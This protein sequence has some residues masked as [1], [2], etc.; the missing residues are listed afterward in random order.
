MDNIKLY[1]TPIG[2]TQQFRHCGNPL[3]IDTYKGCSFGCKYCFA[4]NRGG[5]INFDAQ[6]ADIKQI[7][8]TFSKALDEDKE[9]KNIVVEMMRHRVPLH[10]GGM[11]D[12][13]QSREW[14]HEITYQLLEISKKYNYPIL[15]STKQCF[16]PD[17]YWDILNPKIHA[18]QISLFSDDVNLL[19]KFETNT[20]S[21]N[22]RIN[23]IK[24][25]HSRGFWVGV[26]IQPLVD[27]E[28]AVSLVKKISG[29]V[30]Y[31][32]VEH[33]K[34]CNDNRKMAEELFSMS[35]HTIDDYKCTGRNYE[36]KTEI[37]KQNVE[38][39]KAVSG[40]PVGC[41][42]ND[43]HEFSDSYCCCGI[44]TI[45]ENFDNWS[46]YNSMNIKMTGSND[47]WYPKCNCSGS[48]N[49]ECVI[50]GLDF[51]GYVDNYMSKGLVDK[52]CNFKINKT[53]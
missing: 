22:E 7:K 49:S 44:D 33:L 4:N 19:R 24:E 25:L 46:K 32:T 12:P 18:F 47:Y 28:S 3:R 50:K 41:G 13:F 5:N 35:S 38:R 36:L 45:N 48:F 37:K 40:C 6:I 11:S 8:R 29:Y 43:L 34:I 9:T 23:F 42:D 17:K 21:P 26:R 16:L 14:K 20:P 39:I 30:D 2:L 27:I 52:K 1:K 53:K 10:L 51:K 31:I 15:M